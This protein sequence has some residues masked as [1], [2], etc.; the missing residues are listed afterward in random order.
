MTDEIANRAE[1]P[2]ISDAPAHELEHAQTR[3]C[4]KTRDSNREPR[5]AQEQQAV[6]LRWENPN[7]QIRPHAARRTQHAAAPSRQP[8]QHVLTHPGQ[9]RKHWSSR[10][11][12]VRR[13]VSCQC[14]YAMR[15]SGTAGLN[16]GAKCG[17]VM[18]LQ[19]AYRYLDKAENLSWITHTAAIRVQLFVHPRRR[20]GSSSKSTTAMTT[21]HAQDSE[22]LAPWYT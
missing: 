20:P 9:G 10:R 3:R 18:T 14:P 19:H 7:G 2:A 8:R 11:S 12:R 16:A 6:T 21:R 1:P 15:A 17:L 5:T 4:S 22:I 13:S